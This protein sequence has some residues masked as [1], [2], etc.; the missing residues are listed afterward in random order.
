MSGDFDHAP[1]PPAYVRQLEREAHELAAKYAS[2]KSLVAANH[3]AV[4]H[5]IGDLA[6][7][8]MAANASIAELVNEVAG[9]RVEIS[10]LAKLV[11]N[12]VT[13]LGASK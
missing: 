2:I 12:L 8:A 9:L 6:S 7:T 10:S 3:L 5:Q 1:T 11:Q 4:L 13:H